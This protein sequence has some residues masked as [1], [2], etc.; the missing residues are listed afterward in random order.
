MKDH[1]VS[2]EAPLRKKKKKLLSKKS[3][4][5]N[6]KKKLG[7]ALIR[8]IKAKKRVE[9]VE[10][11]ILKVVDDY[12]KLVA[13]DQEVIEASIVSYQYGFDDCKAKVAQLFSKLDLSGVIIE[14]DVEEGEIWEGGTKGA[15]T[16]EVTLVPKE[17]STKEAVRSIPKELSRQLRYLRKKVRTFIFIL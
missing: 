6:L 1:A 16:E 11:I 3:S 10:A 4:N 17:T 2:M 13:F 7:N 12:K 8:W 9:L 15:S 14:E 5:K